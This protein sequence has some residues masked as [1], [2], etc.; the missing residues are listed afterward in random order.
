[1]EHT[2]QAS[3]KSAYFNREGE[4]VFRYKLN[5]IEFEK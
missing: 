1:M 2:I 3:F 4:S 5:P